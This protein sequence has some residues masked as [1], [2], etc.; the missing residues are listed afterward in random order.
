MVAQRQP[1]IV[2]TY[3]GSEQSAARKFEA[4]AAK[5]AVE[6]YLP[7]SQSWAR[8]S[9]G[10]LAFLMA[11]LLCLIVIGIVIF[12]YM[13]IVPPEGTLSVTYT[14]QQPK[15]APSAVAD[16]KVCPRCAEHVKVAATVCRFCGHEFART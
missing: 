4:D 1:V 15:P 9:Y 3:Q 10:C 5:L 16:E 2:K 7:T 14:L 6:G 8:G 11:L 12:I 13:L